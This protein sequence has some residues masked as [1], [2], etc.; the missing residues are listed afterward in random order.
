MVSCCKTLTLLKF[1][2]FSDFEGMENSLKLLYS[3]SSFVFSFA[4]SP[5]SWGRTTRSGVGISS[6]TSGADVNGTSPATFLEWLCAILRYVHHDRVQS[7][8]QPQ[9]TPLVGSSSGCSPSLDRAVCADDQHVHRKD[10]CLPVVRNKPWSDPSQADYLNFRFW[11]I[12]VGV[13]SVISLLY[14]VV[15]LVGGNFQR[16]FVMKYVSHCKPA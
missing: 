1:W 7:T 15:A 10:L 14:W 16:G 5:H 9:H 12:L 13:L 6:P 3:Y 4:F 11:F 2:V 8:V